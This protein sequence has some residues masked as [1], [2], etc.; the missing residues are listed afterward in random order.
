MEISLSRCSGGG[1][2]LEG[3]FVVTPGWFGGVHGIA[4]IKHGFPTQDKNLTTSVWLYSF[5][6]KGLCR[7]CHMY[8]NVQF[9]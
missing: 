5:T 9:R 8:R 2:D 7:H 1:G 3:L 6:M 4:H